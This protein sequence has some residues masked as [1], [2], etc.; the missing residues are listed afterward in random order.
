MKRVII[1]EKASVARSLADALGGYRRGNGHFE[2]GDSYITWA[3]G[4]L[5]EL[6]MPHEYDQA[7]KR[8]SLDTLPFVPSV[9]RLKVI[10]DRKDRFSSVKRLLAN[11]KLVVNACDAGREGELIFRRITQLA[12]YNGPVR[13]LWISSYTNEAIQ[14]GFRNLRAGEDFDGLHD[15]ARVR[16]EGDWIVGLNGTRALTVRHGGGVLLTMGRVQTPVLAGIVRREIEIRNFKPEPYWLVEAKFKLPNNQSYEGTWFRPKELALEEALADPKAET[17]KKKKGKKKNEK[18]KQASRA[19]WISSREEAEAIQKRVQGKNG[20]I[21]KA[22]TKSRR[23]APPQLF[24]LTSLQRMAHARYRMS[25]KQTLSVAQSLYEKRKLI[26]YPRTDSRYI[27]KDLVPS[28]KSRLGALVSTSYGQHARSLLDQNLRPSSRVVN[29]KKVTDHH[30]LMPTNIN[31]EKHDLSQQEW[32]IYDL[33]G[34]QLVA[35]LFP[36]AV[37]LDTRIETQVGDDPADFFL[38]K[39]RILDTP[40]WRAVIP[41][42][43]QDKVLPAI[44]KSEAVKV[45][46][47]K[48]R[49]EQTKAPPRYTEG[50]LLRFME[51]AGR[52]IDDEEAREAMK[53]QGL[54]TPATRAEIIEKLKR[55]KYIELSG[56]ALAPTQLGELLIHL[57]PVDDMKSPEMTGQWEKRIHEIQHQKYPA[58]KLRQEIV[59]L[60]D[61]LITAIKKASPQISEVGKVA[62][63]DKR[64]GKKKYGKKNN[65]RNQRSSGNSRSAGYSSNDRSTEAAPAKKKA[66]AKKAK[67]EKGDTLGSCPRCRRGQVILGQKDFGCDRWRD[68]CRF[69]LRRGVVEGRKLSD[70]QAKALFKT[71]HTRPITIKNGGQSYKARLKMQGERVVVQKL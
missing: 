63:E 3:V 57:I 52:I 66:S 7:L 17:P 48:L 67:L 26:T 54:G 34:R 4:H 31:P 44:K 51:T 22:L 24:D 20:L 59:E 6:L 32:N 45:A 16:S 40:G 49:E 69:I 13:R 36:H 65:Y 29:D 2:K 39:G 19:S 50:T 27:S 46:K 70:A 33:I 15:C 71:G 55:Q 35:A 37:W 60:T 38:T 10:A 23:E 47:T 68:G 64:R 43:A 41:P 62:P 8:W 58:E 25:A 14:Q 61:A 30:A 42:R 12:G 9:L 21:Q 1:A 28:L 11:A 18:D 5:V 56:K 53:E